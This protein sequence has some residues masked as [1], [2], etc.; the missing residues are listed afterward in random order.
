[1]NPDP[2]RPL[3]SPGTPHASARSNRRV[4]TGV[5]LAVSGMFALSFAAVPLYGVFCRVTGYGGTT[6]VSTIA[7]GSAAVLPRTVTVRFDSGVSKG[8]PWD[9]RPEQRSVT[10]HLGEQALISYHAE[11]RSDRPVTGIAIYNVTPLKVGIY[12]HKIQC[13]CFGEQTLAP[14]QSVSMP[15]LFYVDPAMDS[16]PNMEDVKTITLSYT[17]FEADS[18]AL[19]KALERFYNQ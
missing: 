17:F 14:H 18:P 2:E 4:L 16:D 19:E 12:F 10:A 1:M 6:Q 8:M 3:P 7:P 13:F 9:F 15:V 5:V 11:N